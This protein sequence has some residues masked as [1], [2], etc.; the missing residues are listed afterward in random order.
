MHFHE[1]KVLYFGSILLKFVPKG[2]VD[3]KETLVQVM[4]CHRKGDKPLHE[5]MLSRFIDAYMRH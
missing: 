1:W 4:A 3:K 2:P 5:P